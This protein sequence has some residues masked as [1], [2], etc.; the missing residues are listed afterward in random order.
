MSSGGSVDAYFDTLCSGSEWCRRIPAVVLPPTSKVRSPLA[1][2]SDATD[3][4]QF[5]CTWCRGGDRTVEPGRRRL[6]PSAIHMARGTR[7]A[8]SRTAAAR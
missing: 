4:R 2:Q 8:S 3:A 5:E 7:R 1:R 6:R